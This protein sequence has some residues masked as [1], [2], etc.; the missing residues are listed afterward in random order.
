MRFALGLL[1]VH[2]VGAPSLLVHKP[3]SGRGGGGERVVALLM[4]Q[5]LG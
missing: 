4:F 2:S 5:T 3:D 1:A